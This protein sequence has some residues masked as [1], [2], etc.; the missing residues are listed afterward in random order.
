MLAA[1]V[2]LISG[3]TSIA[4]EWLGA[5]T[6]SNNGLTGEGIGY[7]LGGVAALI[8]AIGGLILA[9]R[10][11]RKDPTEELLLMLLAKQ[12]GID[13]DVVDDQDDP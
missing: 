11:P 7:I 10:K 13:P 2:A 6:V 4:L 9:L 12:A 1:A 8:T 3:P 5:D